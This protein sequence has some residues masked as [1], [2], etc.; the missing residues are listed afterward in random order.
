MTI[1][2]KISKSK[3]IIL[4]PILIFIVYLIQATNNIN[5][6]QKLIEVKNL[7]KR[8]IQIHESR[9]QQQQKQHKQHKKLKQHNI[10]QHNNFQQP[11]QH[12]QQQFNLSILNNRRFK[13]FDFPSND[14]IEHKIKSRV[15]R[16]SPTKKKTPVKATPTP[17]IA[18]VP[19]TT[20]PVT[21]VT[22][23][24]TSTTTVTQTVQVHVENQPLPTIPTYTFRPSKLDKTITEPEI[25]IVNPQGET[26]TFPT[27]D[28]A[29]LSVESL[30]NLLEA[31][32]AYTPEGINVGWI[33]FDYIEDAI[34]HFKLIKKIKKF[35]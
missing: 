34:S 14:L 24:T 17:K 5:L 16:Q 27:S 28:I 21:T 29:D 6:D 7:A 2:R 33:E 32:I 22:T 11:K 19:E 3:Y 15:R 12:H 8:S 25:N 9:P 13:I 31:E 4:L 1:V 20:T 18:V 10:Q 26:I 35:F 23:T 30:S